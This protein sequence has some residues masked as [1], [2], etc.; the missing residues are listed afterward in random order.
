M[1]AS[2]QGFHLS[3]TTKFPNFY[4]TMSRDIPGFVSDARVFLCNFSKLLL[5]YIDSFH[6]H[7]FV[8]DKRIALFFLLFLFICIHL[9]KQNPKHITTFLAQWT[10]SF[11]LT[12]KKITR[13]FLD[14]P[15]TSGLPYNPW[16]SRSAGTLPSFYNAGN[17]S[18]KANQNLS[19]F[20]GLYGRSGGSGGV[21]S[22]YL[23][24]RQGGERD[25]VDDRPPIS[26]S[27][28]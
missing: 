8:T 7:L 28:S 5:P 9:C 10:S 24:A 11:S 16:F 12:I 26:F 19:L 15:P 22:E 2:K 1:P 18:K 25:L 17:T 4:I 6:R 27:C 13:P 14:F 21:G 23:G 20:I 3:C